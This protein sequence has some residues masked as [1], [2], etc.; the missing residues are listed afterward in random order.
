ME[1]YLLLWIDPMHYTIVGEQSGTHPA[2]VLFPSS[3]PWGRT[4]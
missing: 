4:V 3:Q 1:T 2:R